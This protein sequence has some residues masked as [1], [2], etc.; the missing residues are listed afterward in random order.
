MKQTRK[1]KQ[2]FTFKDVKDIFDENSCCGFLESISD[3]KC[4][5]HRWTH[6][7][8]TACEFHNSVA[9]GTTTNKSN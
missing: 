4:E 7:Q 9:A 2:K 6:E 3:G 8:F 5:A 1:M